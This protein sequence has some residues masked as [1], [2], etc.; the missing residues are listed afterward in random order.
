MSGFDDAVHEWQT[1]ITIELFRTLVP[2]ETDTPLIEVDEICF[3]GAFP[4]LPKAL[5]YLEGI[6]TPTGLPEV[7]VVAMKDG[8]LVPPDVWFAQPLRERLEKTGLSL[9]QKMQELSDLYEAAGKS[10]PSVIKIALL[11]DT[12]EA[13]TIRELDPL[14]DPPTNT[15]TAADW[16]FNQ[17]MGAITTVG[18]AYEELNR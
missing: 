13:I 2:E 7:Y 8:D 16:A 9:Q 6:G 4:G 15:M 5:S 11:M 17:W 10:R 1:E 12:G 14:A 3:M 18:S